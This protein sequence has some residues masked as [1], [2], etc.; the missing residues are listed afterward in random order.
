MP[1]FEGVALPCPKRFTLPSTSKIRGWKVPSS[2]SPDLATTHRD[3]K[4][5]S[6]KSQGCVHHLIL[7]SISSFVFIY[8]NLF[9][10][11][12]SIL[13]ISIYFL[14]LLDV[15]YVGKSLSFPADHFFTFVVAG[16]FVVAPPLRQ[17]A[18]PPVD[19]ALAKLRQA[20]QSAIDSVTMSMLGG[21]GCV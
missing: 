15:F 14:M 8:T 3:S 11:C 4:K 7:S 2:T 6:V 17:T 1:H 18:A 16:P 5:G 9:S 12:R 21:H 13:I 20:A 10:W 19:D